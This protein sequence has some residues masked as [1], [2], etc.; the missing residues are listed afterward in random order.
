MDR[1]I[2]ILVITYPFWREDDNLG[3]SYSNIFKGMDDKFEFA[4]IYCKDNMPK[5][6]LCY[7]YFHL[8]EKQLIKSI[9]TRKKVGKSFFLKDPI[10][11]PDI[12]NSV[13]YDKARALRWE[14][15]LM[16]R[17][18]LVSWGRWKSKELDK[19]IEDFKPDVIFGSLT[20]IPL[21][22]KIMIYVSKKYDIPLVPYPWDDFYSLKRKSNSIIYWIRFLVERRYIRKTAL[23]SSYMYTITKQMKEEYSKYFQKECRILYKGYHF[24]GNA[25]IKKFEG[26][27]LR[28]IYMG[29]IG[30]GRWKVLAKLAQT[31]NEINTNGQKAKLLVYT[32]SPRTPEIISSLTIEGA[33][34]MMPKV[35]QSETMKVMR[36]A[37]I[38]VHVEPTSP[39]EM[40]FYR[41]S[42]STKL[43]DYFYNAKCVMAIGGETASMAYL[44]DNDSGIVENNPLKYEEVLQKIIDNP[45]IIEKYA[46]KA[47]N[48]GKLN[49]QIS[50]I[51]ERIYNDFRDLVNN[52]K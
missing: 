16:A 35:P 8:S 2:R 17:D 24:E 36:S 44:R 48:C 43:V 41:L 46:E 50:D 30:G 47:W 45:Q 5:N 25:P 37:D 33:C 20:Y 22:N 40:F 12:T 1:K 13:N 49:H 14:I 52:N 51:Q 19:F 27:P 18:F 26:Y 9:L 38:L 10:N 7:K 39:Q 42:F 34:E 23:Q 3:N 11:T 31:I 4:H 32:M 21:I 15:F 28:L 6:S 29:N